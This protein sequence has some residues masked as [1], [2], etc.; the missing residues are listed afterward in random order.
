MLQS[1][2]SVEMLWSKMQINHWYCI[3][4]K[5]YVIHCKTGKSKSSKNTTVNHCPKTHQSYFYTN[6]HQFRVSNSHRS[7]LLLCP[8]LG[9]S[10]PPHVMPQGSVTLLLTPVEDSLCYLVNLVH[11]II[12]LLS[13][14]MLY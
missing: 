14:K 7:A 10:L 2:V 1:T 3:S 8:L 6:N 4:L 12:Y 9:F 5:I 11:R 13:F